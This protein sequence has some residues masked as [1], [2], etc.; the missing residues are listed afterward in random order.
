MA[1]LIGESGGSLGGSIQSDPD[2]EA[3]V[4]RVFD[5][6]VARGL[7][8]DLH[9]DKTGDPASTILRLAAAETIRR[10]WQGRVTCGHCCSL[11][12][13]PDA[14]A[15]RTIR[16]VTEAR[17]MVVSLPIVNLYLQDRDT[18]R[19]PRW[20]GITRLHELRAAGVRVAV[21]VAV[22]SDNARDPFHGS[23]NLDM[24]EVFREAVRIG[25]LDMPV[26]DWPLAV[27][28]AADLVLF[29][30]RNWGEWLSRPQSHRAVLRAGRLID[31]TLPS[32][33]ELD[34]LFA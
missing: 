17:V 10:G 1:D 14:E 19:T 26:G 32:Y 27:G 9:T 24:V 33:P 4:R 31:A 6:A 8:I 7:D 18:V 12:T 22:A 16:L 5:L 34:Y 2:G 15:D 13:Q 3:L 21:A 25:H 23:G 11:S 28:A 29:S 20:R 30:A